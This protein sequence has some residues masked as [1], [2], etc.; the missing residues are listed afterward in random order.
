MNLESKKV[1]TIIKLIFF[2]IEF[3]DVN[4]NVTDLYL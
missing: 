3:S 2:D 4:K 1:V